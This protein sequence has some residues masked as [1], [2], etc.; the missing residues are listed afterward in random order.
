MKGFQKLLQRC[1]SGTLIL[2]LMF[3]TSCS[4][5]P[6]FESNQ[7]SM[8]ELSMQV[9]PKGQTGIYQIT[10]HTNLPDQT[11]LTVQA[12]RNLQAPNPKS[13]TDLAPTYSILA[14]TQVKVENGKWQVSLNL[15]Q[16]SEE[17]TL[18]PWQQ[19]ARSLNLKL[20][21]ESQVRFLAVTEPTG[22]SIGLQQR[23]DTANQATSVQFTADGRSYLQ[24][25][26]SLTIEPP[27]VKSAPRQMPSQMAVKVDVQ[28]ITKATDVE[29]Q[30]DANLPI[31]GLMR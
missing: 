12:I 28:S 24:A 4:T 31:Q 20:Q 19:N 21:P 3:C 7:S 29:Q 2:L 8:T 10:G 5:I 22:K 27:T 16:P 26:Q 25:K 11:P 17:G 30:T 15:L 13:Q 6:F 1:A 14:Q 9:E 23:A 18:E